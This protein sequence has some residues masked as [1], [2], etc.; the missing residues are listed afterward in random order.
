MAGKFISE[1]K[2]FIMRGNVMDMAVG[3]IIGAAFTKIV[4]SLVSDIIMPPL[5]LLLGSVDFSNW[6]LVLKHPASDTGHY[7]SL[8]A[9]QAAGATTINIGLFINS[10]ISFLIVAFAVFL[11]IKFMNKLQEESGKLIGGGEEE[12][13][14]PTTKVCAYCFTDIPIKAVRGPDCTSYLDGTEAPH[15]GVQLA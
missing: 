15:K 4:N 14:A 6:Y 1:F 8:A 5:G 10:I 9:A 7:A 2:K 12:A 11:L 3:I 13:E